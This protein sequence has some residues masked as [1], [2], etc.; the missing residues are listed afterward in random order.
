MANTPTPEQ[1]AEA[2]KGVTPGPWNLCAHLAY[3]NENGCTCGYRGV[4]YA[5][6]T[7]YAVCQPGHDATPGEEGLDPPR[8]P[9]SE[10]IANARFI[11]WA[12]NN[13][14][15]LAA[16]RDEQKA[17]ADAMQRGYDELYADA[18]ADAQSDAQ[19]FEGELW[20]RLRDYLTE[21]NLDWSDYTEDGIM[22]EQAIE[23]IREC[24]DDET[25]RAE[26]AEAALAAEKAKVARLV[27]YYEA[28]EAFT[29]EK[30][31]G[32][33]TRLVRARAA[34]AEVQE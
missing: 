8:L 13:V 25:A 32:N 15:A 20:K 27:E 10:E 33:G 9:R 23:H 21:L 11:A 30:T 5:G 18:L 4:I 26:A 1:V 29:A 19:E 28:A 2:L 17:R 7:D 24:M 12:R 14:E 31:T 22:A 6:D 16:D 3:E 34:I